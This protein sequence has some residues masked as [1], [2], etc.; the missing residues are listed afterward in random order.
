MMVCARVIPLLKSVFASS[1]PPGVKF[2]GRMAMV[3]NSTGSDGYVADELILSRAGM[4]V[5]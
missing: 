5:L 2:V 4:R 1:Q 3:R